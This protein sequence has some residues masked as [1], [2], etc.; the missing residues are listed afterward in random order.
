M[1]VMTPIIS[2]VPH[3]MKQ[4]IGIQI[5]NIVGL[6]QLPGDVVVLPHNGRSSPIS[7]MN[8]TGGVSRNTPVEFLCV[9][10]RNTTILTRVDTLSSGSPADCGAWLSSKT[11][12]DF[13]HVAVA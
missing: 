8:N 4:P 3:R 12:Y 6:A 9:I 11:R 10:P 1:A 5:G 2:R 7:E 13:V